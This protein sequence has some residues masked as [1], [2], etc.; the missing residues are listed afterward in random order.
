MQEAVTLVAEP[1]RPTGTRAAR[2][3]RRAGRIPAV[4]YGKGIEPIHVSVD[5]K[6]LRGAF[7]TPAGL[8]ALVQLQVGAS[9]HTV[10]ARQIQRHPIRH[11]V[12]HVDFVVVR[13]DEVVTAEVPIHLVGEP[14]EVV[15]FG[16]V[17]AHELSTLA[18]RARPLEVP[19]AIEVDVSGMRV[20][21]TVTVGDLRLPPGVTTDVDPA[22][23]VAHATATRAAA[24]A[25]SEAAAATAEGALAD[26]AGEAA[27]GE[28]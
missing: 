19:S 25:A 20:G 22:V 14:T 5:A 27:A 21:D 6:E 16:G 9:R 12:S 15:R 2:R 11:T 10:M 3:L 26:G 18:V 24:H 4:V 17:M 28:E 8:N 23:V 13:P 1:D 7:S